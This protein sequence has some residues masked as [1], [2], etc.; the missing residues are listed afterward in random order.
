MSKQV[1]KQIKMITILVTPCVRLPI[2]SLDI[3]LKLR[4]FVLDFI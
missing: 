4:L 2:D 1:K 3:S